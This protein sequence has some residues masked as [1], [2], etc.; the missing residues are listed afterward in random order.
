MSGGCQLNIWF[1]GK[2]K[3]SI[4][5]L[6]FQWCKETETLFFGNKIENNNSNYNNKLWLN[7]L[8]NFELNRFFNLTLNHKYDFV[9]PKTHAH[10]QNIKNL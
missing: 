6:L 1:F 2:R 8:Y 9:D 4:A 5:F 3:R 10:T 7:R